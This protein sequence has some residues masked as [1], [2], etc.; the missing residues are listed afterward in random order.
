M[1]ARFCKSRRALASRYSVFHRVKPF[2]RRHMRDQAGRVRIHPALAGA[3]RTE[4]SLSSIETRPPRAP[5]R[6]TCSHLLSFRSIF[7]GDRSIGDIAQP[8][9]SVAVNV[10]INK[11]D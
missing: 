2:R 8:S 5:A 3:R 4:F 1:L 11:M 7:P 9:I 6:A 10:F